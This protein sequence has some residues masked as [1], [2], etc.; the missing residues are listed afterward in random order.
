MDPDNAPG[1]F[2]PSR[3]LIIWRGSQFCIKAIAALAVKNLWHTADY[4]L[5]SVS[6]SLAERQRLLPS[7]HTVPVLLWDGEVLAGTDQ[8]CAFL[9]K[10][11]PDQPAL[12]PQR[13]EVTS[14]ETRCGEL[15]W[16]NGWLSIIDPAGMERYC[17]AF[18]RAE[19]RK[20][21]L[22][23]RGLVA[24]APKRTTRLISRLLFAGGLKEV[25][26]RRG[27]AV[28]ARLADTKPKH[29]AAVRREAREELSQLD[30]LL[31]ASSTL[32]FCGAASPTAADLTLYGMLER[33][34]GDML[35]P[36]RHG[37]SQPGLIDDLPAVR[38]AFEE[39]R[40]MFVPRCNLDRL[41]EGT[42]RDITEPI[43][44]LGSVEAPR[45]AAAVA[46]GDG[47]CTWER[48]R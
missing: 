20:V 45:P 36:N 38:A 6:T 44:G 26:R 43:H 37:A 31:A 28:G 22:I 14:I 2:P 39:C 24:V 23:A 9:D 21:S 40:R 3:S 35:M 13:D 27:G 17:G 48:A 32:W 19:A 15:Y 33:W 41:S 10:Q 29:A 46:A 5:I 18:V 34:V 8:I 16:L 47:A 1:T 30:A 11:F 25:L 12:Y 7:P 4:A 42:Y